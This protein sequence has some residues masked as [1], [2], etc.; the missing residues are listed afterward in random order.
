MDKSNNDLTIVMSTDIG[1]VRKVQAVIPTFRLVGKLECP[2]LVFANSRDGSCESLRFITRDFGAE[3]IPWDGCYGERPREQALSAFIFG[4]AKHVKT[5]YH[6]KIDSCA[7]C[8]KGLPDCLPEYRGF[9]V[10]GNPC[11]NTKYGNFIPVIDHW[12][13]GLAIAGRLPIPP[14]PDQSIA[15]EVMRQVAEVDK[16]RRKARKGTPERQQLWDK[17]QALLKQIEPYE[18]WWTDESKTKKAYRWYVE[19]EYP[20]FPDWP[21]NRIRHRRIK[22]WTKIMRTD[23]VKQM[24]DNAPLGRMIVPSEDTWCWRFCERL[25]RKIKAVNFS[26]Y[27]WTWNKRDV[28]ERSAMALK[29]ESK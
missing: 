20:I 29:G 17:R 6:F 23:I 18:S 3:V 16:E 12:M 19:P 9:A 10:V 24:A 26:E 2:I 21:V 27:G 4:V 8:H 11:G 28:P 13:H 25:G 1:H 7:V 14:L 22:S 5:E 15:D